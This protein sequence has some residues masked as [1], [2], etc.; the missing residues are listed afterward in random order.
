MITKTIKAPTMFDETPREHV[1]YFNFEKP[2]LVELLGKNPQLYATADQL[3]HGMSNPVDVWDFIVSM[4]VYSYGRRDG[5]DFVKSDKIRESFKASKVYAAFI[6]ELFD[7]GDA[8]KA[9]EFINNVIP[10]EAMAAARAEQERQKNAAQTDQRTDDVPPQYTEEQRTTQNA[11]RPTPQDH[12]P[13]RRELR[14]GQT[15]ADPNVGG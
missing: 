6:D 12:L 10:A 9:I 7:D 11:F 2:E 5:D 14:E 13:S 15:S 4:V 8:T 1:L 3:R